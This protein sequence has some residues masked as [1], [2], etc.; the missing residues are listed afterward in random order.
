MN[1]ETVRK[2]LTSQVTLWRPRWQ[3]LRRLLAQGVPFYLAVAGA[4]VGLF[5]YD[6]YD[7][8]PEPLNAR[9]VDDIVAQALASATPPPSPSSLAYQVI[10]PSIVYI[11]A[12][13]ESPLRGDVTQ[14]DPADRDFLE[15]RTAVGQSGPGFYRQ[16]A[17]ELYQQDEEE[18]TFGLGAGVFIN[19]SG[20]I[21][22]ALHVVAGA[23]V[24]ELSFADGTQSEAELIGAEPDNDIAVLQPL[25]LPELFLPATL[26]NPNAMQIGDEAYVVG[27][28]LD[29]QASISA[30]VISG[31]DRTFQPQNGLQEY[32][33]LIQFDAAVNPGSSG[34][35]LLN[36]YGQVIG[37]VTGLAS[38]VEQDAFSGIGLAVP[39]NVAGGAAGAPAQ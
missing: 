29:L 9:Q 33:G 2:F 5:L 15:A 34:G 17:A 32:T 11:R 18:E 20:A 31:F 35:P 16:S 21:L 1:S 24:I 25:Q 30:G 10:L 3:R 6:L 26:G 36:R 37:I 38:A 28:P 14:V 4:F 8:P 39:I 23:G 13:A 22:T 19:E 27:H 7:P 12:Y